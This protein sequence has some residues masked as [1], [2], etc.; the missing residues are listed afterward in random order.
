MW[1]GSGTVTAA[2][3]QTFSLAVRCVCCFPRL[4]A[5]WLVGWRRQWEQTVMGLVLHQGS[6]FTLHWMKNHATYF[7]SHPHSLTHTDMHS[8]YSEWTHLYMLWTSACKPLWPCL[9]SFLNNL[10][11]IGCMFSTP[12]KTCVHV[13]LQ[14]GLTL[15]WHECFWPLIGTAQLWMNL[16]L[17]DGPRDTSLPL[18]LSCHRS[19]WSWR[20]WR[21]L[22]AV[23]MRQKWHVWRGR[24]RNGRSCVSCRSTRRSSA[25]M[26]VNAWRSC[27][28][29][30]RDPRSSRT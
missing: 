21:R 5:A 25:N 19:G 4:P 26:C 12:V 10:Q 17:S 3:E 20:K 15:S 30:R 13:F 18:N 16:T 6:I 29:L 24:R 9:Y 11:V 22:V 8:F 28:R 27:A 7:H 1:R 2:C 14:P 23:P